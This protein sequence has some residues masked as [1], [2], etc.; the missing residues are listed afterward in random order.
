ACDYSG[1]CK[2]H[3]IEL[4]WDGNWAET[5]PPVAK[6]HISH[7]AKGDECKMMV[8]G[9]KSFDLKTLRYQ[10]LNEVKLDVFSSGAK[11]SQV[12]YS[13]K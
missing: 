7:D 1:G 3:V 11:I 2:E 4:F 13:Y 10:G 9:E 6:L 5:V 8:S 12:S